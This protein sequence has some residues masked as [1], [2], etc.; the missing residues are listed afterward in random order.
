MKTRLAALIAL[1]VG[2]LSAQV[3]MN[4]SYEMKYGDGKE[5]TITGPNDPDPEEEDYNYIENILEI[6]TTFS[7]GIYLFTQLEYSD[8]PVLGESIKGL[9]RFYLD[10]YWDR[11][12]LKA[13]DI[14]S[15]QGRGLTLNLMQDQNIDYDNS[16]RGIEVRYNVLDNLSLFTILGQSK[17]KY[18]SNLVEREKDLSLDSKLEFVGFEYEHDLIGTLSSSILLNDISSDDIKNI[19]DYKLTEYDFTWNG[20]VNN[21]D[22]FIEYVISK[23][24][25][26]AI[27]DGKKFYSMIYT[28]IYDYGITYEY[29]NYLLNHNYNIIS[30][31]PP[32]VFRESR[33]TLVSSNAH[34]I[35]WND[36]IG[37]QIEINKKFS[38]HFIIKANTSLAYSH[39]KE[40]SPKISIMDVL[41]MDG[42]ADIYHQY[43]FRQTYVE[44][45]GWIDNDNIYYKI[46]I[47]KFDDFKK[48]IDNPFSVSALTFPSLFTFNILKNSSVTIYAE[49]QAREEIN[50]MPDLLVERTDNY[51]DQYYSLTYNHPSLFSVTYFYRQELYKGEWGEFWDEQVGGDYDDL[52][53]PPSNS[54]NIESWQG[55]DVT[56]KI[57][58][59]TQISLF[60]GSQKGGLVCANGICAVQPGF[61]DGY[62][63]TF[64]SLF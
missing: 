55:I 36:E 21:I 8:A 11:L 1:L 15:L 42:K 7:N 23:T 44:A 30:A 29:K 56:Y 13:G 32:I 63:I 47:D 9:S 52:Y 27:T 43:P 50:R 51:T 25:N 57:N 54:G 59:S 3:E 2:I 12:Y 58:T 35:N 60:T 19:T 33:S 45:S 24:N 64:R 61:D 6:N 48:N 62:K 46:G 38:D 18:R 17:Y 22:L 10:Y 5:V 41:K 28:D 40:S 49:Y 4:Y 20:G 39:P 31:N 37:H 14:Y 53:G 16:V 26:D 34:V